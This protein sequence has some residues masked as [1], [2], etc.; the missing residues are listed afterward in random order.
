[1]KCLTCGNDNPTNAQ[2]CGECG[3]SLSESVASG[4]GIGSPELSMVNFPDAIKLGFQRYVDFKGRSSR[5][6][7]W[8]WTLFTF[9]GGFGLAGLGSLI[10][11]IDSL[12]TLFGLGVLIPGIAV[13]VRRL[14]DLGKSGWWLLLV[15][16]ILIGWII[17]LIW[18]VKTGTSD[19]NQYGQRIDKAD[20]K[21]ASNHKVIAAV[22]I[23]VTL[24]LGV[25]PV[26]YQPRMSD[27]GLSSEQYSGC[28]G[29][30]RLLPKLKS[31]WRQS[32]ST[33]YDHVAFAQSNTFVGVTLEEWCD[34]ITQRFNTFEYWSDRTRREKGY[35]WDGE[36]WT[37]G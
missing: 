26:F 23:T 19:P 7:Y 30:E 25:L 28:S 18:F 6:E 8:W 20:N 11:D 10:G 15:L 12:Q 9:L 29:V 17:L 32:L 13:G 21:F 1:M 5:A 24:L 33:E 36:K 3:A 16:A 31:Y 4:A 2:F 35:V 37:G 22:F 14:H 34:E 27:M